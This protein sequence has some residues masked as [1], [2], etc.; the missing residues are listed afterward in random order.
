MSAA[1]AHPA[2]TAAFRWPAPTGGQFKQ[3]PEDFRVEEQL[4]L[5]AAN[6]EGRWLWLEVE[7]RAL[8]TGQVADLLAEA[9]SVPSGEIRWAGRKDQQ[10]IARQ[11]FSLPWSNEDLSGLPESLLVHARHRCAEPLRLGRHDGNR[12]VIRLRGAR[13]DEALCAAWVPALARGIPNRF[14]RQRFGADG[15]NAQRGADLLAGNAKAPR[16]RRLRMLWLSA[17]QSDLFNRVLDRWLAD[18][19]PETAGDLVWHPAAGLAI[20]RGR[21]EGSPTGPLFGSRM[22]WPTGEAARR[23]QAVLEAAGWTRNRME[24]AAH[25][26]RL[27]GAR[28][29]L[30]VIPAQVGLR[31]HPDAPTD[32]ELRIELPPGSYASVVADLLSPGADAGAA[33]GAD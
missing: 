19:A 14:G 6:P 1:A 4:R 24:Q 29:P 9:A 2:D 18:G 26:Q 28:R 21:R 8:T 27:R 17:W 32:L 31:P 30:M 11:W 22:D 3:R 20:P 15:D 33:T 23:E 12:F 25:R 5:P 7:R 10:A 13:C 16:D